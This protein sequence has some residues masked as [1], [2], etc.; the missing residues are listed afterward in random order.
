MV[1]SVFVFPLVLLMLFGVIEFGR[2]FVEWQIVNTAARSGVRSASLFRA[3]CVP[4]AVEDE[5]ISSVAAVLAMNPLTRARLR[6]V[7][8]RNPCSILAEELSCVTVRLH[9]DLGVLAGFANLVPGG[10]DIVLA[11]TAVMRPEAATGPSLG[12]ASCGAGI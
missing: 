11:S 10:E 12:S 9:S 6:E 8:V 4:A 7:E 3:E 2:L 5:V 1:E